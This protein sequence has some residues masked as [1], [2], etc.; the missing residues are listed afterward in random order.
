MMILSVAVFT[1][2]LAVAGGGEKTKKCSKKC[3]QKCSAEKAKACSHADKANCHYKDASKS[4]K[5]EAP[6][7]KS[8]KVKVP[9]N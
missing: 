2:S 4:A 8:E 9:A 1:V 5:A 7:A 6:D 3:A